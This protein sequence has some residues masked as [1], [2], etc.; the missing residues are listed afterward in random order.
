MG[1]ITRAE[2]GYV[3]GDIYCGSKKICRVDSDDIDTTI[4]NAHLIAAAVNA[5]KK[6][7]PDNPM[8][9]AESIGDMY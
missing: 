3:Y 9:A 2:I 5:C 7:N 4:A 8:A 6:I 1:N